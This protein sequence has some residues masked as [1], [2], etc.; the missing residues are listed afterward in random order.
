MLELLKPRDGGHYLD[1]GCGTGNYT[2][3]LSSSHYRFTGIDPSFEML[4]MAKAN[5]NHIDWHIGTA[6]NTGMPDNHFDGI[7]ASLTIHHWDNLEAGFSE[8][9]RVMKPDGRLVLFTTT[10]EQTSNYWLTRYFPVMMQ[11]S[12]PPLPSY[13]TILKA[14]RHSGLDLVYRENYEVQP[15]LKDLFLYSGKHDP[16]RY[17]DPVFRK[18]ISSFALFSEP[19]EVESG[20][21]QLRDDIDN[22]R[23]ESIKNQSAHKD[24]D[25]LFIVVQK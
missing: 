25:Y 9:A 13:N 23:F 7:L 16:E 2:I 17:F 21:K 10:P 22:G 19:S 5:N 4:N 8:M 12:L 6:E 11:R 3:A 15:D 20:L 14:L 24:G 1:I 18:G